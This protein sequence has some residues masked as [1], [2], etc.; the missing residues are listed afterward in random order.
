MKKSKL[1]FESLLATLLVFLTFLLLFV[2]LKISFKPFNFIAKTVKEINLNDLYFASL[3]NNTVDTNIVIVNIEDLDRAGINTVLQ[4]VSESRAAVV[5]LDVFFASHLKTDSDSVLKET[6]YGM[7]DRLVMAVNYTDE[8]TPD[9]NY[10]TFDNISRGHA[11]ILTNENNTKVVRE[12]EPVINTAGGDVWSFA[13]MVTKKYSPQTFETLEKRHHKT[14][15]LNYTGDIKAFRVLSYHQLLAMT[16]QELGM[17]D[18]K[19]VLL[20]FCGGGALNTAD[21]YD[22]FYTP[23]G[24]ETTP[25]R[26]PDM[27]GVAIHANI[28]SML[29]RENYINKAPGWLISLVV[30]LITFVHVMLFTYFYVKKHLYYHVVAKLAQLVSFSLLLWVIFLLFSYLHFYFP[31][32]YILLPVI[33][34]VDVLYLYEALAV[35]MYKKFKIKSLF[36]HEH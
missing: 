3:A 26:R 29:L 22:I 25:N 4:K 1:L 32:K 28:V 36:I 30:F 34:A 19:I 33:L 8:G 6:L 31:A 35:L 5:G 27:Y 9:I 23:V 24:F 7:R 10:W 21:F 13:A 2:L 16:G 18:N 14:E 11:G 12:F 20:G 17:L 15:L